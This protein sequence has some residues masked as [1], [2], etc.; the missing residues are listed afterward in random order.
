[1]AAAT[2]GSSPTATTARARSATRSAAAASSAARMASGDFMH[3][4]TRAQ[5]QVDHGLRE[6]G[7]CLH[8]GRR[9]AIRHLDDQGRGPRLEQADAL[10]L[11]LPQTSQGPLLGRPST[12][13]RLHY[14]GR[15]VF[16]TS[17]KAPATGRGFRLA[18]S[19]AP[20]AKRAAENCPSR[21]TSGVARAIASRRGR[22]SA[23]SCSSGGHRSHQRGRPGD[24]AARRGVRRAVRTEPCRA[25]RRPPLGPS[26]ELRRG[27]RGRGDRP[28]DR[29]RRVLHHAGALRL[30]QDDDAAH[31]RRLRAAR[32][33]GGRAGRARR[34]AAC[35]RTTARSTPCS[36]TT[37]CSRT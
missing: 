19:D 31:D 26:Q 30:R 10:E 17:A 28:R 32:R 11:G 2:A 4:G 13:S 33:R 21:T 1:M 5:G 12:K 37:R 34:H 8:D 7:P 15:L 18:C 20:S 24:W 14:L 16:G 9:A 29:P 35:P 22:D 25:A 23:A 27:G 6:P 3:W 36:R